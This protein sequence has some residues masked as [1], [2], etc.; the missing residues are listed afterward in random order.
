MEID[1]GL[2][3]IRVAIAAGAFLDSGDLGVQS[4]GN[5]VGN[6]MREVSEDV[7]QMTGDQLGGHDHRREATARR[8]EVPPLPEFVVATT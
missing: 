3:V 4:F 7:G 1:G 8:P 6:A 5:G 2:E